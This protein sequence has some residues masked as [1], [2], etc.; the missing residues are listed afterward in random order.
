MKKLTKSSTNLLNINKYNIIFILTTLIVS[1][2]LCSAILKMYSN[3]PDLITLF[4]PVLIPLIPVYLIIMFIFIRIAQNKQ[5]EINKP[6]EITKFLFF[7]Y[8]LIIISIKIFPLYKDS[9]LK[10]LLYVNFFSFDILNV[11]FN[12]I[13]TISLTFIKDLLLFVPLGI[14]LPILNNKFRNLSNCIIACTIASIAL[15]I[16]QLLLK[17][18]GIYT[19]GIISIDFLCIHIIGT[20]VGCIIYRVVYKY[21]LKTKIL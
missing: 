2:I 10:F 11:F 15:S 19:S 6:I 1:F 12:S 7:I 21:N 18:I 14:F 16:I 4:S 3:S 20:L 9:S 8:F 5:L 17:A 13:K